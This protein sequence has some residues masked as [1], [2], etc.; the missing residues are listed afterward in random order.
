MALREYLDVE[1]TEKEILKVEILDKE[2]LSC[3]LKVVD[4]LQLHDRITNLK[5]EV[6]TKLTA[7]KFE[8]SLPFVTGSLKVFFNGLK[9]A[10]ADITEISSTIFQIIDVTV[11]SDKI[12]V[13]Y[14]KES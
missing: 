13:E 12:E 1:I 2:I 11:L 9:I 10:N 7:I 5:Q 8:T 6:P 3:E 14:V 4:I